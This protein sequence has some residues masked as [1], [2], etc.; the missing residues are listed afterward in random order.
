MLQGLARYGKFELKAEQSWD[1]HES[2]SLETKELKE[3]VIDGPRIY[4]A[5]G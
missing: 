4:L 5:S 1:T 2:A 3:Q